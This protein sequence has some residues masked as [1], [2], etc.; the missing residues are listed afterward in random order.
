MNK[1]NILVIFGFLI[2]VLL[3]YNVSA[4]CVVQGWAKQKAAAYPFVDA[5][6]SCYCQ[7]Q[8]SYINMYKLAGRGFSFSFGDSEDTCQSYCGNVYVV[9]QNQKLNLFG[10]A[11]NY[12]MNQHNTPQWD[13]VYSH[14][15]NITLD[16]TSSVTLK[17]IS[18]SIVGGESQVD[19]FANLYPSFWSRVGNFFLNIWNSIINFF[20]SIFK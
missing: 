18:Q 5:N 14:F 4:E 6:L 19:P 3:I 2:V 20:K 8:N 15:V 9:A 1:K 10:R 13:T 17:P 7:N 11:P 12:P 16:K